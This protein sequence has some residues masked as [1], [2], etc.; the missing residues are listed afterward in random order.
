MRSTRSTEPIPTLRLGELTIR[1]T[2]DGTF[3]LDGGAMFG[4]VPKP[5]WERAKP[6]DERNRIEMATNCPLIERGDDLVLIDTGLGGKGDEKFRRLFAADPDRETLP[7]SIRRAGYEPGDVTHV[8]LSHLHFDHSGWNTREEAGGL[9]PTFPNARYWIE[10]GEAEHARSPNP[11]DR[12]SY[13]PRNLE[14]LFEAGVVELFDDRAE[15]VPGVRAVKAPGH[16]RDMCVVLLDGGGEDG[17]KA[18]FLADLVPTRAHVPTPWVMGY[19]LYPV[20]TMENKE[21]WLGRAHRE[22]WLCIFEHEADRPLARL[23]EIKPGR[24]EAVPVESPVQD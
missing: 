20:T 19:D 16:N 22:G 8:L 23:R 9:V 24:Y 2:G 3:G 11:R 1:L 17:G 18:V 5:L 10:R 14:P 6:A 4:V 13:D 21:L 12:A 15:P 7:E